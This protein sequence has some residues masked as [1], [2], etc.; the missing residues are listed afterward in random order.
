MKRFPFLTHGALLFTAMVWGG[1]FVAIKYLLDR[2]GPVGV[3]FLRIAP[4]SLC[5]ALLLVVTVA[6]SP[7]NGVRWRGIP[8]FPATVWKRLVI[9]AITGGVV[10]N[11]ALA[12]GQDY[13]SAAMAS[14]IATSNPIFT[15][16]FS[17]ILIG[18]PLTRRKL[19]G[20]ALA[21]CGFLIILFLGR[22]DGATFSVDNAIGM[23]IVM[24]APL[25]WAIYT[26]ISKPLL[27]EY[28]PHVVAGVTTIMSLFLLVPIFMA[29]PGFF[30]ELPAITLRDWL[31][32]VAMSVL[33]I[34]VCYIIWYRGLRNLEPT[35]VAVYLY[36]VPFFGVLWAWLL[37]NESVTL[38]LILGGAT[39][40][41]G[42]IVTNSGR[43]TVTAPIGQPLTHEY[44]TQT[45]P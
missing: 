42:V 21:C 34:F 2:I 44:P 27:I 7:T 31:A 5:F 19:A 33:A 32:V 10:N 11:L 22:G 30:V 6:P 17:R 8:A 16:I 18:E 39:I 9:I 23:L 3:V 37:L 4:A 14:L 20:I 1:T 26:V 15:A 36:L 29:D 12:Y 40:I 24:T 41:S 38:W 43:R 35:Q 45:G 25:G 13:I 28:Q